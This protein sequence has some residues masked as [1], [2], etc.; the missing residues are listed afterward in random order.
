MVDIDTFERE[1]QKE[2]EEVDL[3]ASGY[4]WTCPSCGQWNT[5]IEIP[6]DEMVTCGTCEKS[7]KIS[8]D[9]HHAYE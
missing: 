8:M 9:F 1:C 4:D 5:V 7:F 3:I 6:S 2:Q